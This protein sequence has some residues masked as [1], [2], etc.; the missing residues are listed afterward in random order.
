MNITLL[1]NRVLVSNLA[2]ND[3]LPRLAPDHRLRVFLSDAV[4]AAAARP[5]AL[6]LLKF[7]EQILF[8]ELVFPLADE[9]GRTGQLLTFKGLARHTV[10]PLQSLNGINRP[11][12]LARLREAAPDLVL[13]IRYGGILRE[14]AIAVPPLGVINLHSGILPDYRGVMATFRAMLAGE[15]AIGTTIHYIRDAGIDTGDIITGTEQPMRPGQSYL[16]QVLDLYPAACEKLLACVAKLARGR[17]LATQPQ[18]GGG[19]YFSFPGESEL[20]AFRERGFVLVDP[21]EVNAIAHRF[22]E[23]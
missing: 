6:E 14:E 1:A 18:P 13:S 23:E 3:L 16:G 9:A 22:I 7:F 12:G 21:A 17:G 5:D 11:E 4:G 10:E 8:N 2:L 20:A 15:T 19:Q